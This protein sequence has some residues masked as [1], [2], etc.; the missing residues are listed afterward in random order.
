MKTWNP[1]AGG[2]G[3]GSPA[4]EDGD[5]AA[6]RRFRSGAVLAS[7]RP[8]VLAPGAGGARLERARLAAVHAR[9][10]SI[11]PIAMFLRLETQPGV[12]K[13]KDN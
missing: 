13:G 2:A 7:P 8:V 1:V 11:P 9:L 4:A 12:T 10:R 6:P 3:R 5:P